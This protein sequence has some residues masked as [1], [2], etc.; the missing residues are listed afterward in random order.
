MQLLPLPEGGEVQFFKAEDFGAPNVHV[1]ESLSLGNLH[2]PPYWRKGKTATLIFFWVWTFLFSV[3]IM[4]HCVR[5]PRKCTH[6]WGVWDFEKSENR[7]P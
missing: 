6:L 1:P 7:Q 3:E 2:F 5:R 4:S